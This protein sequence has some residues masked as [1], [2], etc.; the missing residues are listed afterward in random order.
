[1]NNRPHFAGTSNKGFSLLELLLVL[2]IVLMLF[3]AAVFEFTSMNRGA[4]LLEGADR[5][6]S[7]F[8]FARN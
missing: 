2:V 8:R 3:S 6:E 1:M 7:L 4:S 5:L